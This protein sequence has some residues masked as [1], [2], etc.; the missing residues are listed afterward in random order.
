MEPMVALVRRWAVDWLA[1][2]DVSVCP[3]IY[4]EGFSLGIGGHELEGRDAYVAATVG[5][6]LERW[7]GVS[8]TVHEVICNGSRAAVRC[9]EHGAAAREGAQAAWSIVTLFDWDGERFTRGWAE[10]DY[11]ARRRQIQTR[12]PDPVEPPAVAPWAAPARAPDPAAEDV[13][14]AW[15]DAGDF[16]GVDLDD[17]PLGQDTALDFTSTETVVD[18]LFSAGDRV[19]FHGSRRGEHALHFAGI[20][21]VQD[22]TVTGGRVIRDRLGLAKAAAA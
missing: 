2:G 8:L 1:R 10:E 9:S 6:L 14:R 11:L 17:G 20:V 18:D 13:V 22:G 5:G 3:E 15:L 16:A 21:E 19:A 4:A 12:T 7:P